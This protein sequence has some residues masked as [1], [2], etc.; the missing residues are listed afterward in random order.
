MKPVG[1]YNRLPKD[2][3]QPERLKQGETVTYKFTDDWKRTV[4]VSREG[5][6]QERY[7]ELVK[8][9]TL[10]TILFSYKDEKGEERTDLFDIGLVRSVDRDGLPTVET[11][12]VHANLAGG[13]ITLTGGNVDDEKKYWFAELCNYNASNPNRDRSKKEYFYRVDHEAIAKE[14]NRQIDM[15]LECLIFI[16]NQTP[17]ELKK[18]G[19]AFTLPDNLTEPQLRV[20]LNEM[21]KAKPEW[22]YKNATSKDIETKATIQRAF[23][24]EVI[25]YVTAQHKVVWGNGGSTIATLQRVEGV[26]WQ[27]QFADWIKT[28]KN[29]KDTYDNIVKLLDEK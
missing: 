10:D 27:D 12:W 11:W 20:K 13:E 7:P 15:E 9:P 26:Q 25:K 1:N 3:K 2:F 19:A 14:K 6:K 22:F 8:I 29:G 4:I 28:H 24:G 18:L 17:K 21:A 23:I 5:I 16:K